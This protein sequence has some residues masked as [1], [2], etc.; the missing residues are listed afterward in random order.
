MM[1][2]PCASG[3]LPKRVERCLPYPTLAQEI[4]EMQSPD[5]V[6]RFKVHV[7]RVE[8]DSRDGVPADVREEISTELR[9]RVFRCVLRCDPETVYL[10]DLANEIAEVTVRGAFRDRGYFRVAAG[11]K[12]TPLKR[13]GEDISVVA[14]ISVRPGPQYRTGDI[15][16]VSTDS[17]SPLAMQPEV[18][19]RLIP[20]QR[21]ELFSTERVRQGLENLAR[22]YE[23]EGYMDVTPEPD[24]EVD[25]VRRTI[26]LVIKIDQQVQYRVGSIEFLG[27]NS[28]TREKLMES[29]PKP[30]EIFDTAKLDEF[31]IVNRTIL[32]PDASR[33][34]VAVERHNKTVRIVFDL[35]EC[36]QHS[37]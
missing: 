34:D 13:E 26:D 24:T 28:S 8:F 16:I 9:S 14:S 37:N 30:G 22:I 21:G 12:L 15:R 35:R 19:R 20:L 32:P 25:D 18:L 11:A 23:R 17:S 7:I 4:R 33:D 5:L 31:F 3:Q 27:V 6:P 10:Y 1:C 2:V 29:L 36:P